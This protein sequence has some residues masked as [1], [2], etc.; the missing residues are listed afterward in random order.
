MAVA[1]TNSFS[2]RGE[3]GTK[4]LLSLWTE[5]CGMVLC[6]ALSQAFHKPLH[7]FDSTHQLYP[8]ACHR[9]SGPHHRNPKFLFPVNLPQGRTSHVQAHD[10]TGIPKA[11]SQTVKHKTPEKTQ[12]LKWPDNVAMSLGCWPKEE[13]CMQLLSLCKS[14]WTNVWTKVK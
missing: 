5:W 2:I 7:C 11:Y 8:V 1:I 3:S 6:S 14:S 13:Y 9:I 4:M 10:V 12:K